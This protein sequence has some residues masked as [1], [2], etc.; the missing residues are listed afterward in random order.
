ML[1]RLIERG[2]QW[3]RWWESPVTRHLFLLIELLL[4]DT[5]WLWAGPQWI[6]ESFLE[7]LDCW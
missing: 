6:V 5:I 2:V 7:A 4:V 3:R 1:Q